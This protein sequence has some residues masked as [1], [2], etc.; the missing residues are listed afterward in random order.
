MQHPGPSYGLIAR[1][2]GARQPRL[3]TL[4]VEGYSKIKP[5]T[6]RASH[7]PVVTNLL[8]PKAT[9]SRYMPLITWS[10]VGEGLWFSPLSHKLVFLLLS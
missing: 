3:A 9:K 2:G 6:R 4:L 5:A 7:P 1:A 10:L 8:T